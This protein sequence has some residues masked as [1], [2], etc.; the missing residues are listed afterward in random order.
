[1][2]L[3]SPFATM[4]AAVVLLLVTGGVAAAGPAATPE[5]RAATAVE[6]ALRQIGLPFV[7][8]G[9]GP[10]N[11]DRGFDCSGLTAFAYGKAGVVLPRT[12]HAQYRPARGSPPAP[13]CARVT[14]SSTAPSTRSTTSDCSSGRTGW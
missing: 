5:Q 7:W 11:G 3:R 6:A 9:N 4:L 12:A 8:G 1:M 14:W 10:E 13:R 2:P